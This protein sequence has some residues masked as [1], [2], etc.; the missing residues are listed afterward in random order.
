MDIKEF[1]KGLDEEA[2]FYLSENNNSRS[3]A[4]TNSIVERLKEQL[5][6]E[7]YTNAYDIVRSNNGSVLG[8]IYGYAI[9][10]NGEVLTLIYSLPVGG[11]KLE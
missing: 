9:S 4:F 11:I 3:R 5:G 6:I 1:A 2:L 7:N 8:E 10:G